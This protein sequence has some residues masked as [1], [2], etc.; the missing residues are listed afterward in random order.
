MRGFRIKPNLKA[1]DFSRILP[2]QIA[3]FCSTQVLDKII[4]ERKKIEWDQELADMLDEKYKMFFVVK[5]NMEYNV[6]SSEIFLPYQDRY[7]LS[8]IGLNDKGKRCM[9]HYLKSLR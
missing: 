8:E 3:F 5:S 2:E 7:S 4:C 1:M 9:D 6:V